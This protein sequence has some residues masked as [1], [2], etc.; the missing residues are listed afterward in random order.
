MKDIVPLFAHYPH[1][2]TDLIEGYRVRM[3]QQFG[4]TSLG[5]SALEENLEAELG[6]DVTQ[7]DAAAFKAQLDLVRQLP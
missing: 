2:K 3:V 1:L 7:S 5:P 4:R 6:L